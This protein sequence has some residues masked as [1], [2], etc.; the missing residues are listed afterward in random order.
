[1]L[2][3]LSSMKSPNCKT[4]YVTTSNSIISKMI[5]CS[6]AS[7]LFKVASLL[8][9]PNRLTRFFFLLSQFNFFAFRS[10]RRDFVGDDPPKLLQNKTFFCEVPP[11]LRWNEGGRVDG[12][13]QEAQKKK[14]KSE[15][16][17]VF[18]RLISFQ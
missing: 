11:C 16:A 5:R 17:R 13:R 4:L 14:K 15:M 9:Q 10:V 3:A 8:C 2:T 12:G 1:M 18:R 6:F 7:K